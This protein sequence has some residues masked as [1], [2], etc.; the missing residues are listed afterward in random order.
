[1][2]KIKC[3]ICGALYS[4]RLRSCPQCDYYRNREQARFE[5]CT[6]VRYPCSSHC[7]RCFFEQAYGHKGKARG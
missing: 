5:S 4:A 7:R 2:G 3:D 6:G 1:M